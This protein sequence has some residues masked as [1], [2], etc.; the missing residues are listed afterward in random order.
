[1][2]DLPMRRSIRWWPA[3]AILVAATAAI[4][5]AHGWPSAQF[6]IRNIVIEAFGLIAVVLLAIW[7][8]AFSRTPWRLRLAVFA[9][10]LALGGSLAA[11]FR[12][13]GVTGDFIPVIEPRWKR[14]AVSAAPTVTP[15]AALDHSGRPD[16]PQY[17]GPH[18]NAIIDESPALARDWEKNPPQ[19]LW[20][21]PVGTGW[22]GFAIVGNRAVTMEQRGENETAT[23]LDV[24]TGGTLWQHADA[25]RFSSS[26]GG[27]G[28][29]AT[30]TIAEGR[31]FTYGGTGIVNCLALDT[32]AVI[33]RHNIAD[34]APKGRPEW[35]YAGS[36]LVLDGKVIVSAG[37]SHEKSLFALSVA[38]G[39]VV[40]QNG[41][42]P[43]E[44]SSP[45]SMTLAGVPQIVMFNMLNI[46]AHD[47]ATGAVLWEYPWGIRQPQIAQPVPVGPNRVVFSSGYGVGA[48]LLE[49]TRDSEGKMTPQRVWKSMNLKA[50]ISSFIH[51]DG[52]LYGLDDGILTCI[53]VRDGSRKWKAGRYGHGQLL[54][55]GDVLLVTAESGEIFLL[56]PTPDAANELTH[57]RVFNGKTW[58]PPALSGDILL[59]R[60][61]QEAACVRLPR[62]E[63]R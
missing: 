16:F 8:I 42:Q 10:A 6:Q 29:R 50:K 32:G 57:F 61:D 15:S 34:E 9:L 1:M 55:A 14:H 28:P 21:Q 2:N 45:A 62:L 49:I 47:A 43:G 27:E 48:E 59:M 7:W 40:W 3:V 12:I 60:T 20:R 26:L 11:A 17:L 35:G 53:D 63:K 18:R 38:D 19:I 56:A 31:V 33:W 13:R 25:A 41:S 39:K 4:V 30:P 52:Y 37:Q 22:S 23:C 58:N 51:R 36:P 5:V 44:Y 54:L 24:L 46:T